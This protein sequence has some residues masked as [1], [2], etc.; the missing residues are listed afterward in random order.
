MIHRVLSFFE[1]RSKRAIALISIS[2]TILL[3]VLD[4]AT[5]TEIHFLV[6]YLLPIALTS[7]YVNKYSGTL[8]SKLVRFQINSH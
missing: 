6:I 2:I 7:W 5:N 4:F 3:G 8:L 1:R